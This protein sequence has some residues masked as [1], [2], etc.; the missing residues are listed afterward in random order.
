MTINSEKDQLAIGIMPLPG[1]PSGAEDWG[2]NRRPLDLYSKTL[3]TAP[4][5]TRQ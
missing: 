4:Q 5:G 3:T 1:N 2:L